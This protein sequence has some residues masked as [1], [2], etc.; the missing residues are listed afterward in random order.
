MLPQRVGLRCRDWGMND[1][2]PNRMQLRELC[3]DRTIC[4]CPEYPPSSA[5]QQPGR[6]EKFQDLSFAGCQVFWEPHASHRT[7]PD[8]QP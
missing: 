7:F 3:A 8:L 6:Q 2:L 1:R 5:K 4:W